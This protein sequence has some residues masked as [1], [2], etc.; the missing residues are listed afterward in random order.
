M[1]YEKE[2]DQPKKT[3]GYT[4]GLIFPGYFRWFTELSCGSF[5][6]LFPSVIFQELN[7]E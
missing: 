5:L 7:I 4:F 1:S 6:S 3:E 2:F